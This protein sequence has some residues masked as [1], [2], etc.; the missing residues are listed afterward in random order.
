[1]SA[2]RDMSQ[3][4]VFSDINYYALYKLGKDTSLTGPIAIPKRPSAK[5]DV[6]VEIDKLSQIHADIEKILKD[7]EDLTRE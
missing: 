4:F 6:Q 3:K 5:S 7:L 1:M 2:S